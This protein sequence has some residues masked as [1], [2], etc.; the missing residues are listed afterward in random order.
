L[1]IAEIS[2]GGHPAVQDGDHPAE[3][4]AGEVVFDLL[5]DRHIGGVARSN[6]A[7]HRDA[8]P[9]HRQTDYRLGEVRPGVLGMPPVP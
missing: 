1:K 9:G 4:P 3:L 8:V 2:I 7:A 6:P 5:D